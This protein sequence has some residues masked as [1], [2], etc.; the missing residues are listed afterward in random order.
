[1]GSE[2]ELWGNRGVWHRLV[3]IGCEVY[4]RGIIDYEA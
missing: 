2:V 1:M 3:R 4:L